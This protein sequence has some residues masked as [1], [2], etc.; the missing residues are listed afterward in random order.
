MSSTD[1]AR[2]R[3]RILTYVT[4]E[5]PITIFTMLRD[6]IEEVTEMEVDLM[7]EDRFPGP[8]PAR[9]NPFSADLADIGMSKFRQFSYR[10]ALE[11]N[12]YILS[13]YSLKIDRWGLTV[14]K[15]YC[16]ELMLHNRLY[17]S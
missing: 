7:V 15:L 16:T 8:S 5:V 1:P 11:N 12:C 13:A 2:I 3:L 14:I 9:T 4:P 6:C 10:I 17:K